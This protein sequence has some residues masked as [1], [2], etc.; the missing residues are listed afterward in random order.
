M[1]GAGL[2]Q[3]S[4]IMRPNF[5]PMGGMNPY[6]V[7]CKSFQTCTIVICLCFD[8]NLVDGAAPGGLGQLGNLMTPGGLAA[9]L[10]SK[11]ILF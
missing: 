6:P 9:G 4:G 5:G 8:Q 2:Q 3:P 7:S 11:L 10:G 1:A